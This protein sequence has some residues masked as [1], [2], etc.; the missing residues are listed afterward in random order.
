[1]ILTDWKAAVAAA[2]PLAR[3]EWR[4]QGLPSP[5]V[6]LTG[7][8]LETPDM[9]VLCHG[10]ASEMDPGADLDPWDVIMDPPAVVVDRRTGQASVTSYVMLDLSEAVPV[11]DYP[12][13]LLDGDGDD[14]EL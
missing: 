11:G 10:R 6:V 7:C 3:A 12:A 4:A 5:H 14:G 9:W 8:A 1:M 2:A 13:H